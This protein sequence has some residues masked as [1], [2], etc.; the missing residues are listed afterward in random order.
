MCIIV[1]FQQS[2]ILS[3]IK[4]RR[5]SGTVVCTTVGTEC[6]CDTQGTLAEILPDCSWRQKWTKKGQRDFSR[7][8]CVFVLSITWPVCSMQGRL[9]RN[10][11]PEAPQHRSDPEC[12]HRV[13]DASGID[14]APAGG[15]HAKPRRDRLGNPGN[16][17][18]HPRVPA[19]VPRSPL[20]LLQSG[21]AEQNTLRQHCL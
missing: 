8:N 12:Q 4:S 10:L 14:A 19:S 16:P 13:S 5:L 9:Q 7:V 18:R 6:S 11:G 17:D 15:V 21:N 20:E 3:I 2:T 1:V